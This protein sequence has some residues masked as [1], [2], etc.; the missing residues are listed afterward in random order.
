MSQVELAKRYARAILQLGHQKEKA[1]SYSNE[2]NGIAKVLSA[3]EDISNFF[4]NRT[5]PSDLKKKSLEALFQG[6][7]F[8]EDVRAF[9]YLLI[10]RSRMSALTEI[11]KAAESILDEEEG[12]TRGKIKASAAVSEQTKAGYEKKI[13][14]ALGKKI[15]LDT[16]VDEN[17]MGGVRVE[18]GGWTFDDSIETHL[19]QLGDQLLKNKN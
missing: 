6:N 12:V 14:A 16:S 17:I 8:S 4:S 9:L 19:S 10:D 15:F 5:V 3:Q 13:G 1:K 2:I 7:D 11:A 18:I